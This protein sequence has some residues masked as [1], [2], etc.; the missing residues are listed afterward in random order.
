MN[1]LTEQETKK[2][3]KI[4]KIIVGECTKKEA[5][6]TL[7]IT[8]RQI[9]RLIIKFKEEGEKGFTH[10]NRGKVSKKKISE[11]IK[12]E[13]VDLYITEYFDYNFTHFYEEIGEKYKLSRKTISTILS[14]ADIISPEAHT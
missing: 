11:D 13:I 3:N 6:E 7:G 9:D 8:I 12:K 1:D 10:K 2:L 5:S 14:E 4:K